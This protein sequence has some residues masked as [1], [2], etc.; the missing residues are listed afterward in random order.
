M[1]S[2]QDPIQYQGQPLLVTTKPEHW[3]YLCPIYI[4]T[5]LPKFGVFLRQSAAE[6][7]TTE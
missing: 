6:N 3:Q 4:G 1:H 2:D 5:L 7:N